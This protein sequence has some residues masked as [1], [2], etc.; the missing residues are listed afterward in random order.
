[1]CK[2]ETEEAWFLLALA[3]QQ[4]LLLL[5]TRR[6]CDRSRDMRDVG[7]KGYRPVRP[8]LQ[9][10]YHTARGFEGPRAPLRGTGLQAEV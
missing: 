7:E 3:Q 8:T 5:V 6:F 4:Q 10:G 9:A 1:M 2:T